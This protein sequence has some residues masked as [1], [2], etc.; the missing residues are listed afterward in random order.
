MVSNGVVS[1]S[2]LALQLHFHMCQS[3]LGLMRPSPEGPG[4]D[5][6][7]LNVFSSQAR[8]DAADFLDRPSDER[9]ACQRLVGLLAVSLSLCGSG[10]F[11][12]RIVF[13]GGAIALA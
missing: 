7:W 11:A 1:V 13:G 9:W 12:L 2:A 4:D 8:G 5:E 3:C 10:F 6:V